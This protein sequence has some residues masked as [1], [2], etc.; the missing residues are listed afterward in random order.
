MNTE[1]LG[2]LRGLA[3]SL[4]AESLITAEQ[5]IEA[6][7]QAPV[8]NMHFVQYLV[9]REDIDGRRLAELTSHE[10]GLPLFDIAALNT[11][12]IPVGLIDAALVKK[13]HALPLVHR[14]NR[15]FIAVSDPTNF[16]ALEE[17]KFHN[18]A[19]FINN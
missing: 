17:I 14:G 3:G 6:Q 13:H 11:D 8:E 5:A 19:L 2:Q 18:S 10:F 1:A 12:S 16:A 9:E 4:V 7:K 15:L